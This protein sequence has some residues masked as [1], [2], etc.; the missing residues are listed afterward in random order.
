MREEA[1]RRLFEDGRIRRIEFYGKVMEWHT[2]WTDEVRTM[3][4]LNHYRWPVLGYLHA[5]RRRGSAL[6]LEPSTR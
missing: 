1:C 5:L 4:H 6:P 3:Y 2:R